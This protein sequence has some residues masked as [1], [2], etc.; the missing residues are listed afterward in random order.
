MSDDPNAIPQGSGA[1]V[2]P[3]AG[4]APPPR[5]R[6]ARLPLVVLVA[7]LLGASLWSG[8]WWIAT[9]AIERGIENELARLAETG[10]TVD[11]ADRR[12]GGYPFRFDLRCG[13]LSARGADGSEGTVSSLTVAALAYNPSRMIVE[14][15][16]P[17]SAR[18]ADGSSAVLAWSLAHASLDF[19]TVGLSGL[20]V[21][22]E[23]PDLRAG[24]A[25]PVT[26]GLAEL[27]TRLH[28]DGRGSDVALTAE[29][30]A[31]PALGETGTL[32]VVAA[33]EDGGLSAR[34]DA[35]AFLKRLAAEG[36]A[37]RLTE[38]RLSAGGSE[39]RITGP[40]AVDSRGE[41]SGSFQVSLVDP[42]H[43]TDLLARG[44]GI[45]LP[46]PDPGSL[47]G[48]LSGLGSPAVDGRPA[49][50]LPIEVRRGKMTMGFVPLGRLPRLF[51]P[52][53]FRTQ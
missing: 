2:D 4:E 15:G 12:L 10:V 17:L 11:C 48:L 20:S 37:G 21:S 33:I 8:Y 29:D 36:T 23:K 45:V 43:L 7:V 9:R 30:V 19:D 41:I 6:F 32:R 35:A 34:A 31:L 39:L 18:F 51:D 27:H 16:A 22:V 5:R 24:E 44:F 49:M 25:A 3:A 38:V 1:P 52:A 42:Q 46:L 28:P 14:A 53:W 26:A 13:P 50:T 40:F 47:A